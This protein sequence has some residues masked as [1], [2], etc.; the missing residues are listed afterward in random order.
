MKFIIK[1]PLLYNK[2]KYYINMKIF[3]KILL[4]LILLIN[5][6]VV[7]K[8][9]TKEKTSD[10]GSNTS[11]FNTGFS[12]QE[13]VTDNKLNKTINMLKER[14]LSKKQKKL[15]QD[16]QP[17]SPLSDEEHLKNF[18]ES[19]TT[20]EGLDQSHTVMIPMQAY[21]DEGIYIQ[22]GYYKLSC[23]K[24]SKDEYML[25]LSQGT[26][27]IMSVK[28]RQTS[29]DLEQDSISF[30]NAEIITN[31]RIRLIYGSIELNLVGYLYFK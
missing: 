9:E 21:S 16:M 10:W 1:I 30:C 17:L 11:V 13:P 28:A 12:G 27:R 4:I 3:F 31:N 23:R 8:A 22:P 5:F 26:N 19:E 25:D 20:D 6:P 7:C 29:Q 14:S 18:T 2:N 15:R 24:V